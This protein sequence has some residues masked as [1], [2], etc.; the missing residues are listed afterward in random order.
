MRILH[1]IVSKSLLKSRY[2]SIHHLPSFMTVVISSQ[3]IRLVKHDFLFV[4]PCWLHLM[5]FSS[6]MY[7]EAVSRISCSHKDK[8]LFAVKKVSQSSNNNRAFKLIKGSH[9]PEIR[10]LNT[11]KHVFV[12]STV[13]GQ[14]LWTQERT[15]GSHI[16]EWKYK[17]NPIHFGIIITKQHNYL[18]PIYLHWVFQLMIA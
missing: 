16:I 12:D 18:H 15:N 4:N 2:T 11:T 17:K 13:M 5:T 10:Y 9:A 3:V 7:P 6:F 1:K 8:F 14:P